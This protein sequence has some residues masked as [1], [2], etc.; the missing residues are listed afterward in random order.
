MMMSGVWSRRLLGILWLVSSARP[1]GAHN[2]PPFPIIEGKRAGL[3]IVSLWTHPDIGI[4]TFFVIL[5]PVPGGAIPK[6]LQIEIAVQPVSGRLPEAR[7][8]AYRDALR[9]QVEYKTEVKFDVDEI[10]RVRLLLHSSAGDGELDSTVEPTPTGF[11]RWDLL[12]FAAPFL[13][14]GFLWFH[15]IRRRRR[16]AR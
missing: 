7:Y 4:G 1:A 12:W 2:G 9:G 3:C 8:P 11:G 5:D 6:D 13:G 10:W 15:A 16:R 14:A